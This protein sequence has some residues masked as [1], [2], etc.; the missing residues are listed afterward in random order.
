LGDYAQAQS[1]LREAAELSRAFGQRLGLVRGIR[2]LGLLADIRGEYDQ[3]NGYFAESL[4]LDREAGSPKEIAHDLSGLGRVAMHTGGVAEARRLHVEA[5][6]L[7][8]AAGY[9]R[10]IAMALIGLGEVAM[11]ETPLG[12]QANQYFEE[13][14]ATA[15]SIHALPLVLAA[16]V[17]V[18]ALWANAGRRGAAVELLTLAVYHPACNRRTQDWAA[19]Q[20][21]RLERELPGAEVSLAE[22]RGRRR[23]LD[24]AVD[25]LL[26]GHPPET[27]AI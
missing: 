14:L 15:M 24:E 9:R 13:A 22:E 7:C 6:E 10:G 12:G 27:L 20:L 25:T 16:L 18:A 17:G 26:A 4:S 11:L 1:Y 21:S 5:L 8:R 23:Q 3:A 2:A 19:R